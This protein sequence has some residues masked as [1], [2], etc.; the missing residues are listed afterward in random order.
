MNSILI[1]LLTVIAGTALSVAGMLIVRKRV[2]VETLV[3]YHEVAGY[4]LSVVGT[5]Y[6]V[7]LGFIIVGAM[8][9]IQELR[10][11]AE[12]EASGVANIFLLANGL[13]SEPRL[14]IRK[15]CHDYTYAVV[16][17]EWKQMENGGFSPN[18]FAHCRELIRLVTEFKPADA[19]QEGIQGQLLSEIC[20]MTSKRRIRLVNAAHGMA[21]AMWVVLVS[22][23]MFTVLFTYFLG[24]THLRAQILM[25]T[26]VSLTLALNLF[27]LSILN[28]PFSGDL[29]V[30]PDSFRLNLAIFE[31]FADAKIPTKSDLQS[32]H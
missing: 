20:E 23:G 21:P 30:R 17:E 32:H 9:H 2:G 4:L 7:L 12:D 16:N 10:I 28:S 24:V 22:G 11:L 8:Q 26:L 25:T 6:A 19:H 13:P 5:L 18:A 29:A 27:V 1:G 15:Q 14:L 3:S 31:H